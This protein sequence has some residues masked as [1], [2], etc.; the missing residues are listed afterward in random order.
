MKVPQAAVGK[1]IK[2][3]K[4]A[5]KIV[6]SDESAP[7]HKAPSQA[8]Q[9]NQE[10][11]SAGDKRVGQLLI[12]EGVISPENL[13]AALNRQAKEGG[14][15]FENLLAMR[16]LDA[17]TLH[18]FLSK[19]SGV[20][21]IDLKQ[22]EIPQDLVPL[23]PREF[24]QRNV[25]LPIDKMGRLLTVGMACPLDTTTI[26][27]LEKIT[28]LKVKAM[29]CAFDD[30]N[31]VIDRYY[32]REMD[33]YAERPTITS[34]RL[35]ALGKS[36]S[37]MKREDVLA[38]V[39]ALENLPPIPSTLSD[40]RGSEDADAVLG[41]GFGASHSIRDVAAVVCAD[42]SVSAGL[43]TVANCSPYGLPGRVA[44]VNLAVALL[45][46]EGTLKI[47]AS[48]ENVPV[49]N[50]ESRFDMERFRTRSL[51]CATSAMSIAKAS[52]KGDVG[53]AYT[54]GLL[55]EMGRLAL[56]SA[57][58]A[59]YARLAAEMP[60][61]ER[62]RAEDSTFG[63]THAEAGAVLAAEWKLPAS[64]ITSMR[65]H[66]VG[67][68]SGDGS[69]IARIVALG[70]TMADVY[71]REASLTDAIKERRDLMKALVVDSSSLGRIYDKAVETVRAFAK[72]AK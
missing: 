29:L 54:A 36:S 31:T 49:I 15:L 25:V 40:L 19:Q 57:F 52:D 53:D 48:F 5:E 56:A 14:K 34:P 16:L 10:D 22:Y 30:I 26:A 70:A 59:A 33:P 63:V 47:V 35:S 43:L 45:G 64:I 44:N 46:V 8:R 13:E 61:E 39:R 41:T 58:P 51:F 11:R 7:P 4:C 42:P 28:G 72:R 66:H 67:E 37:A 38:A 1:T 20:P 65:F 71:S 21:S 12:D 69:G 2:C 50:S 6:I 60:E 17:K 62:L 18:K 68:C 55:H 27:E 32:P 9:D 3:V 23:I 24:A